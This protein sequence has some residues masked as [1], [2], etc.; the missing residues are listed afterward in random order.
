[1]REDTTLINS[2][3]KLVV[4]KTSGIRKFVAPNVRPFDFI[5]T[6][7]RES[8][9]TINRSSHYLFFENLRGFHFVSLQNLYKEAI[10]GEFEVGEIGKID[11]E[12]KRDF[13]A[14]MKRLLH[15]QIN[16]SKIGRASCRERV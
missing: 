14:D 2:N 5:K 6:M 8:I 4:E 11:D 7:T 3:K 12:T 16:S 1:M 9:S 13:D 10:V 15:H